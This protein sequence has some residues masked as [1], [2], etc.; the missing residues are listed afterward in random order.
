MI[1]LRVLLSHDRLLGFDQSTKMDSQILH[2]FESFINGIHL[3]PSK[4]IKPH[5]IQEAKISFECSLER[6][7]SVSEGP[8][9][10]NL[11]LGHVKLV[12]IEDQVL[13]NDKEIDLTMLNALGRLSGKYY[14]TTHS[15]IESE[16]K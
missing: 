16:K 12:H 15:I 7:V 3:V 9:A 10:G 4:K 14:C 13:R 6:I 5:R 11:I 8:D 2:H 1:S